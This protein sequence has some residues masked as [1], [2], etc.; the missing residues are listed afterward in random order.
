MLTLNTG[1]GIAASAASIAIVAA[2]AAPAIAKDSADTKVVHCYG[3]N[4]C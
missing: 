3:I 4:S 1:L 2:A